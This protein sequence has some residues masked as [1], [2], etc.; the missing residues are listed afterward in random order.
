M[1]HG[2]GS[3]FALLVA[4][5]G[6][7]MIAA[8]LLVARGGDASAASLIHRYLAAITLTAAG[9]T[10]SAVVGSVLAASVA[11]LATGYANALQ[12]VSETQLIQVRVPGPVQGRLF[13][14]KDSVDGAC[15]FVGLIAAAA[16]VTGVGVRMTLGAGAALCIV[17]ALVA[18]V[19]LRRTAEVPA[20]EPPA[21][22]AGT[23]V[24][25][26]LA[27]RRVRRST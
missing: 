18:A 19:L 3:D 12:L 15:F 10:A 23:E 21:E 11:F 25:V 20:G 13:G 26:A 1:L 4:C 9:M 27:L 16:L 22:H 5:Y 24:A 14:A 8:T 2:S 6:A 17:C 7:G